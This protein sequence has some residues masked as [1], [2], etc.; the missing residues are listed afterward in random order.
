MES[1]KENIYN[2]EDISFDQKPYSENYPYNMVKMA[3][4][5]PVCFYPNREYINEFNNRKLNMEK[6]AHYIY[7][8]KE[9]SNDKAIKDIQNMNENDDKFKEKD[10]IFKI[11]QPYY[12]PEYYNSTF[13]NQM[14]LIDILPAKQ[15]YESKK[16]YKCYE[17]IH[18]EK[19]AW[20]QAEKDLFNLLYKTIGKDF[21]K[22]AKEF[23]NRATTLVIPP[24][25][26]KKSKINIED[27]TKDNIMASVTPIP[28]SPISNEETSEESEDEIN[29]KSRK[30]KH[31]NKTTSPT[32]KKLK[33]ND[34]NCQA[35]PYENNHSIHLLVQ[36]LE[37]VNIMPRD[38]MI[39]PRTTSEIIHFYYKYKFNIP[40]WKSHKDIK[41]TLKNRNKTT[42]NK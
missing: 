24:S 31:F 10:I 30:R 33:K 13:V 28:S 26:L 8:K 17:K 7:E 34:F 2:E 14:P 38:D 18:Y 21:H 5:E 41:K 15:L 32:S 35:L 37:D 42:V 9:E 11:N 29:I 27:E 20:T 36:N 4:V 40:N 39:F 6:L 16:Q 3:A 12:L 25:I 1:K 22:M 19:P 23:E